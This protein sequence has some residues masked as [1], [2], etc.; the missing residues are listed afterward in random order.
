[1]NRLI[2]DKQAKRDISSLEINSEIITD[3]KRIASEFNSFFI[4]IPN[5]LRNSIAS[6]ENNEHYNSFFQY[7]YMQQSLFFTPTNENEVLSIVSGLTNNKSPG[8]DNISSYIVKKISNIIS[9]ILSELFNRSM[10]S[11]EFPACLKIAIVIPLFKQG[12][13]E[14]PNCYRPISLLPVFAKIFE[15]I[16]KLRLISFFKRFNYF[17]IRQFGFR[18]GLSTEDALVTFFEDIY[19]GINEN[20]KCSALYIDITKAFDTV[21][22]SILLDKLWMAGVRGLP[23][24]WFRSYLKNRKQCVRVGESLSNLKNIEHGV[25]QGSVLGPI[26]FLVYINDLCNANLYG[27]LTAFADDTA[28]TYSDTDLKTIYSQMSIDLKILNYWFCKNFM[29]LSE[30]TKYMIFNLRSNSY[31]EHDL[32]YHSYLCSD[33]NGCKCLRIDIVNVI[34]YL[35]LIIDSNLSWKS[36]VTKL[37]KELRKGVR[38]FYMLRDLCPSRVLLNAYHALINSR[39]SYGLV[40]WGGIYVSTLNPIIIFQKSFLR[41]MTKSRITEHSWPLFLRLKILPIRNLYVYKVLKLFFIRSSNVTL[42]RDIRYNFRQLL[43]QVPKSNLTVFQ[44]SFYFNAPRLFNLISSKLK[45]LTPLSSFLK[46]LKCYLF[47][48]S[49]CE[50]FLKIM[51]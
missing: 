5:V 10:M 46:N 16:I 26:L 39:L 7:K 31:F 25:P 35:G 11:A 29:V 49:D 24:K 23:H 6:S 38:S 50:S 13:R 22:H 37:K 17:S 14:K 3:E 34:K 2:G 18:G 30:K 32:F 21:D 40:C 15:K 27:K 1:V 45:H 41:I 44:Q 4:Q 9:G 19:N 28:L 42:N 36:H 20:K 43:V 12:N 48:L 51:V 47:T 33:V 8:I